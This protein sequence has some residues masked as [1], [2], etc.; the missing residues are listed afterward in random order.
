MQFTRSPKKTSSTES[1]YLAS[2]VV[3]D[4]S[5]QLVIAVPRSLAHAVIPRDIKG[6][7]GVADYG[8]AISLARFSIQDMDPEGIILPPDIPVHTIAQQWSAFTTILDPGHHV[9][10]DGPPGA[11]NQ[12]VLAVLQSRPE[13]DLNNPRDVAADWALTPAGSITVT[14]ARNPPVNNALHLCQGITAGDP[15][16]G[17]SDPQFTVETHVR[18]LLRCW[19]SDL[20]G[21]PLTSDAYAF[22]VVGHDGYA[23]GLWS[24]ALGLTYESE[25]P[26]AND[27]AVAESVSEEV[28]MTVAGLLSEQSLHTAG[29]TRTCEI[30]LST[31]PGACQG[32]R[33]ELPRFLPAGI[34]LQEITDG[35]GSP[36]DHFEAL[37]IGLI[38]DPSTLPRINL[39]D[40][41]EIRVRRLRG[42]EA[43]VEE[44]SRAN[45]ARQSIFA[46]AMPLLVVL[47]VLITSIYS[48]SDRRSSLN[49]RWDAEMS[50]AVRLRQAQEIR[51]SAEE[52][53]NWYLAVN[54]QIFTLRRRQPAAVQFLVDVDSRWPRQDTSWYISDLQ[55][56]EAGAIEFHGKT[57][58]EDSVRSFAQAL[59]FGGEFSGIQ[60]EIK[61]APPQSASNSPVTPTVQ[62]SPLV[63]FALRAIY[64]PLAGQSVLPRTITDPESLRSGARFQTPQSKG[65][66]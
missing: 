61:V 57:R 4:S 7:V 66:R 34:R 13:N 49:R 47:C 2:V 1:G 48:L 62:G 5:G 60:P 37:A 46:F 42:Q 58:N 10:I 51:H 39:G 23:V 28:C 63:E 56:S 3:D 30:I 17:T 31:A 20:S 9:D 33:E 43:A 32:L 12:S 14:E 64:A 50:E 8:D 27:P 59:E 54:N 38:A 18:A 24:S 65:D 29:F 6:L 40:Q 41:L 11:I 35:D 55:A 44:M 52:R 21:T 19:L 45:R 25:H 36:V 16:D 26:L 53:F 15:G 22:L